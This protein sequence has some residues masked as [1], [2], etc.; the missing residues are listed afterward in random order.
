MNVGEARKYNSK[1]LL[2]LLNS[3]EEGLSSEEAASRLAKFGYNEVKAKKQNMPLKL[4]RKFFE[5]VPLLL[6]LVII[7]SYVLRRMSDLYIISAMLVFNVVVSFI[8]EYRADKAVEQLR[9]NLSTNARTL[10]SGNW[11]PVHSRELVPGDIIRVRSGDI[12]PADSMILGDGNIEVDES[13]ITGES[14]PL[15][16]HNEDM[17]YAGS[18]V[19][20]GEA[21]CLVVATGAE[22]YYG[23]T[24]ILVKNA[25]PKSHI[26]EVIMGIAKYLVICDFLI[27]LAMFA[28]GYLLVGM[29]PIALL[30]FLLVIIVASVPVSLPAAFTVSMAVGTSK[31]ASNSILVTR[32]ESVEDTSTMNVLC[33]DKTGTLTENNITVKEIIPFECDANTVLKYA[34]E[35]SRVDDNDPIDNAILSYAKHKKTGTGK[36]LSFSPFDPSTKK[37]EARISDNG[38]YTVVKG[39]ATIIAKMCGT[40]GPQLSKFDK[41]IDEFSSRGYRSLGVAVK[42]GKTYTLCGII[43]LY[44]PPRTEAKRLIKEIA[45]LGVKAKMLTGDNIHVAKQISREL[46]MGGKILDVDTLK[47][48]KGEA[49]FRMINRADGFANIYPEDKYTIVKA[50]QTHSLVVGMTGDGIND[51]PALKQAEVGIAVSNATD[52]AKSAAALVL[53]KSGIEVIVKAIKESRRIFERM[54]TYALVKISKVY[55]IVLFSGIIFIAMHGFIPIT[56][57]LLILLMFTNDIANISISTDNVGYSKRPDAWKMRSLVLVSSAVGILL[58]VQALLM[59]YMNLRIFDMTTLQFQT[60]IFLLFDI[61]DKFTIINMRERGPFW[62]YKPSNMLL[63]TS[64][65]GIL[66]GIGMAY[67]GILMTPIGITPMLAIIAISALF[68]FIN[69]AAKIWV[70]KRFGA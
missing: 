24:T 22:T 4:L 17:I 14:L 2:K 38:T 16:R 37:T 60:A 36:Q 34:A 50:L 20:M 6:W 49:A 5:P 54:V 15:F 13:V 65:M 29:Q 66:A 48:A 1:Q 51:A 52:V 8:E 42:K 25:M 58:L 40:R 33:M 70:F 56:P 67:Y 68:L 43:A 32:L 3:S 45:S 55:Q 64:F 63:F 18:I 44:D 7:L 53:T 35:A 31:L 69:D 23:K 41:T 62:K 9:K 39:A 27:V 61:S 30:P 19:K 26:Q 47:K 57:F 59:T 46:G 10:R 11:I 12:I 28:Y 21:S